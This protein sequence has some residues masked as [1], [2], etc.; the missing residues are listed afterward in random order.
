LTRGLRDVPTILVAVGALAWLP[1]LV[2]ADPVDNLKRA[3]VKRE[4]DLA[5]HAKLRQRLMTQRIPSKEKIDTSSAPILDYWRATLQKRVG[6]LRTI[7]DLWGAL[8]LKEW[9]DYVDIEP[10]L[11]ETEVG[12]EIAAVREMDSELRRETA[13]RLT[14]ALNDVIQHGNANDRLAVANSIA[15]RGPTYR[16]LTT[17]KGNQVF[18]G[19][20]AGFVRTLTPLVIKL[21]QDKDIG[22]RQEAYRALG[23]SFPRPE[24]AVPVFQKALSSEAVGPKRRA[25][26]GLGQLVRVV[27]YL[28]RP[29]RPA[30]EPK[31]FTEDVLATV[32]PVL[33]AN[34]VGLADSDREV[35]AESLK[36]IQEAAQA[37]GDLDLLLPV[38]LK[39]LPP[40]GR[41]LTPLEQFLARG[42]DYKALIKELS[43]SFAALRQQGPALARSIK[44]PDLWVRLAAVEALESI[45]NARARLKNQGLRLPLD[46]DKGTENGGRALIAAND[47]LENFVRD[48]LPAIATLLRDSDARVRLKTVEFLDVSE[49]AAAPALPLLVQS[50]SDQDRYVRW[51]AARAIVD[52]APEKAAEAVQVL[53]RLLSDTDLSVRLAAANT[54]KEMGPAAKAAVP[55]LAIAALSGDTEARVA[56]MDALQSI[57]PAAGKTPVP[58]LIQALRNNDA[59]VR[60][61]AAKTLGG[62]GP[63][64]SSAIDALRPLIGD[65][66][67]AVRMAASD[68]ISAINQRDKY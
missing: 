52:I 20:Q 32:E 37:I 2:W 59:R 50:L 6:E 28:A 25:A 43:P 41:K 49:E 31:A 64:A 30:Y 35:R 42:Q 16:S 23:T 4:E 68:A 67:A 24:D 44:D 26:E 12:R 38:S 7:G 36:T 47:P 17:M 10:T 55:A 57:G 66:D 60:R 34:S 56:A 65:Y 54:L 53:A 40:P 15:E 5:N 62:L 45:G 61:A 14:G 18:L 11:R 29:G 22:V 39:E 27:N 51:A 19:D 48:N 46:E 1:T 58:Q 9:K 21:T 63:A 8:G 13:T 3:L 33:R